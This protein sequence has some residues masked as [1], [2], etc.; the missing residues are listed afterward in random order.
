MSSSNHASAD[1]N[2]N[3]NSNPQLSASFYN[4]ANNPLANNGKSPGRPSS[5]KNVLRPVA[6]R[7][8]CKSI[9]GCKELKNK[10]PFSTTISFLILPVSSEGEESK[11]QEKPKL[12]IRISVFCDTGTIGTAKVIDGQ[13]RHS[14]RRNIT[15]LDVM[16]R[17]V[18]QPEG[19][20]EINGQLIGV[21][22]SEDE[23][24]DI[25]NSS[26]GVPNFKKGVELADVGLCILEGEREKLA[27][28]LRHLDDEVEKEAAETQEKLAQQQQQRKQDAAKPKQTPT[29]T[30]AQTKQAAVQ[31]PGG[32]KQAQMLHKAMAN[33][34]QKGTGNSNRIGRR[35]NK[36]NN[37]RKNRNL[38][39][40][41]KPVLSQS[42][43][44]M[45]KTK[46]RGGKQGGATETKRSL[47]D[48]KK[49]AQSAR[50]SGK[51]ANSSGNADVQTNSKKFDDDES[52]DSDSSSATSASDIN[53]QVAV[54]SNQAEAFKN[55]GYEFHFKLPAEVM[56]QVDQ[57]L[58][59]IAKMNKV[60]KAV[61]TNGRGT[62]FLYGNGGVAYT[63][64]IPK[65]LYQKLRQ[66]RSSSFSSRPCFVAL[67]TRDRYFVSFNDGSA[68]W[69][70]SSSLDKILKKRVVK[71]G[72]NSGQGEGNNK[73]GAALLPRSVAFGAT[74]DTFFVVFN[75]GS[76]EYQGRSVPKSLEKKLRDR[77]DAADLVI[78]NLG[79]NG[80]WFLKVESGKMWWSG[81]T[82]ELDVVLKKITK[83][84]YLHNMDFG[85]NGSYFVSYDEE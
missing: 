33:S 55:C 63:P 31:Q 79:P 10:D 39:N 1:P 2:S 28:H 78:C 54:N 25:M 6:V 53:K 71:R 47:S 70:G 8:R 48:G 20:I 75:D 26:K 35:R 77:D 11:T 7:E 60:V 32:E 37:L 64:A 81:I 30:Q 18:R 72:A 12:P 80:E 13:V 29:K 74:Y 5:K 62:V 24:D 76:W 59:D 82:P 16:E 50:L 57:C 67:G 66:L 4:N 23:L 51:I 52:S 83:T 15:S 65:A 38:N 9:P 34:G 27:K 22:D 69:K 49:Q 19:P 84:G 68:D 14:F 40:S 36:L 17:L 73:D 44:D 85:E 42:S 56:N 45:N 41:K 21:T 46:R 61:A 43:N 58:R 3:S